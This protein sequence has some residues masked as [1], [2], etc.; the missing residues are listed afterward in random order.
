MNHP[1]FGTPSSTADLQPEGNFQ[2]QEI[3]KENHPVRFA[4]TPPKE[5]NITPYATADLRPEGNCGVYFTH[6]VHDSL[7]IEVI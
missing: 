3:L 7:L 6:R 2:E 4:S 1:A 5:G